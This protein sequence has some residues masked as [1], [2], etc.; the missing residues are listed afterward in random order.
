MFDLDTEV[1]LWFDTLTEINAINSESLD[2]LKDHLYSEIE[3]QIAQGKSQQQAFYIATSKLGDQEQIKA[4]FAKNR[5]RLFKL[6]QAQQDESFDA[7]LLEQE[8]KQQKS[9]S[10]MMIGNALIWAS[11]MIGSALLIK[12]HDNSQSVLMLLIALWFASTYLFGDMKKA[13]KAECAY[14]RKLLGFNKA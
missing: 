10:K 7:L 13:A 14:F 9:L 11:A 2:E 6:C 5:E 3:A 8:D 4:E 12:G 1:N